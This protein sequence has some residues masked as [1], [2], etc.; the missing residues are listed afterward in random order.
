LRMRGFSPEET[1]RLVKESLQAVEMEGFEKEDPFSLRKGERQRV[2]VAS[3]LAAQPQIIILDE[4]TTG[5]DFREQQKMMQLIQ[6]LNER[7]HTILIVTHT[8]WVVSEYAHK[9]AIVQDGRIAAFGKTRDV[10]R[11]EAELTKAFLRVPH[12]VSMS[13]QLGHTMLS[14]DE[15]LYCTRQEVERGIISIS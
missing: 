10:F 15:M 14:V 9:V 7:G 1:D 8:M 6:S 11:D 3:V 13:N 5:L 4:P 12:I 2:A